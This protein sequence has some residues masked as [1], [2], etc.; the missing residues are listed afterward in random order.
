MVPAL[1]MGGFH[2][3]LIGTER[4]ATSLVHE[5]SAPASPSWT[6]PGSITTA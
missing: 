4:E 3:G 5:G 1:G 6:T 2:L